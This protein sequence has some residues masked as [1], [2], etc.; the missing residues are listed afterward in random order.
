MHNKYFCHN[1]DGP[2]YTEGTL[3]LHSKLDDL[4]LT[5]P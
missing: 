2:S 1:L 4:L 5:T 3:L